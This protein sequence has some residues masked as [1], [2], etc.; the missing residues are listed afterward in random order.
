MK[1]VKK[2]LIHHSP[3][4]I[5]WIKSHSQVPTVLNLGEKLRIFFSARDSYGES[6]ITF[7][8]VSAAN[9]QKILYAHP[10]KLLDQSKVGTFD[11][12]G[13]MP[14]CIMR[15][16]NN[17]SQFWLFYSGWSKRTTTPYCNLTGLAVSSDGMNFKRVGDGPVISTSIEDPFSATSPFIYILN[18]KLHMFYS[19]GNG[20][21]LIKEKYEH[22]YNIRHA[23]SEDG[24]NWKPSKKDCIPGINDYEALTRPSIIYLN[25][26]FHMW[27]CYRGSTDFRGGVDSY[28]IGYAVSN[29]LIS[30]KRED[31]LSGI[32]TSKSGWDSQMVCYPY[33]I[34]TNYGIYMFYN[35]NGFGKSGL[36]FAVLEG[37]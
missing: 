2:G 30:W 1:W 19:S 16:P 3:N 20:W 14:S 36:G 26:K 9:P 17:N 37:F 7:I 35:G 4:N 25:G 29:D 11:E 31:Q 28:K 10:T 6:Y 21:H 8:D 27:F 18:N 33:V 23:T 22:T 32:E 24:L 15:N 12:H 5:S 13:T 34:K